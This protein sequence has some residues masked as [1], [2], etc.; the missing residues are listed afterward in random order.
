MY[1]FS[2]NYCDFQQFLLFQN[3][4]THAGR[5]GKN[6]GNKPKYGIS[7]H[8]CGTVD[9]YDWIFSTCHPRHSPRD[10]PT[11]G[12]ARGKCM[13]KQGRWPGQDR[14]VTQRYPVGGLGGTASPPA[15]S[16]A[17]P[18][19]QTH[20]WQQSIENWLKIRSLTSHVGKHESTYF[21]N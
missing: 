2:E 12:V 18:R 8:D 11:R 5:S 4:A 15:G 19:K 7:P 10:M 14:F 20:F 16:G 6:A 1:L 3:K 21:N 17:E 9:T 13:W